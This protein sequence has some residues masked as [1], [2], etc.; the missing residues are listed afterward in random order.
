[1]PASTEPMPGARRSPSPYPRPSGGKLPAGGSVDRAERALWFGRPAR[2]LSLLAAVPAN[3]RSAWLRGVALI[4]LGRYGAA[5]DTLLPIALGRYGAGDGALL[6][7]APGARPVLRSGS[8]RRYVSLALSALGSSARQRGR[9]DRA[10]ELDAAALEAAGTD[11]EARADALV[12]L[13]ADAIGA[14]TRAVA[15]RR[16]AALREVADPGWRTAVRCGWVAAEFSL[17]SDL[18]ETAAAAAY[19]AV[20]CAEMAQAPR[21]L[22]KSLLF[23]GVSVREVARRQ[24]VAP[25]FR[26]AAVILR[27]AERLAAAVEAF[28]V[29]G[30]ACRLRQETLKEV[31]VT[32][33]AV[34]QN[35]YTTIAS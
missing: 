7:T 27:R 23:Y 30:V 28:P 34:A 29:W 15:E 35:T 9:Y 6:P 8:G 21:H 17:L 25:L 5:D 14:G 22:A 31:A 26:S 13:T 10:A 24:A 18:P 16:L 1:M 12:G 33:E 19:R 20:R 11:V 3:P 32:G 4:A 2:A